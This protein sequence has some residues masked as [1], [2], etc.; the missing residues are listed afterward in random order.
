MSPICGSP[1]L[2]AP[3]P[4]PLICRPVRVCGISTDKE[5]TLQSFEDLKIWQRSHRMGLAVYQWTKAFPPDERYGLTSQLRR[6]A[7]SVP[8][9][10]AEGCNRMHATDFAR[11]LNI[12]EGSLGEVRSLL[13]MARDLHY[14]DQ[15]VVAGLLGEVRELSRMLFRFRE[16]VEARPQT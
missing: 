9:N 1:C 13:L 3:S 7:V 4:C 5:V 2:L 10:I 8:T 6:A 14:G 12:S 11:F 16:A 15:A